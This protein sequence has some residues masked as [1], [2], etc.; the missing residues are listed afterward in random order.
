MRDALLV[1]LALAAVY[2]G[3]LAIALLGGCAS[4]RQVC[5]YEAG[6][7]VLQDTRSTVAGT[8]ETEFATTACAAL[9]YSTQDTGLSDNG[10]DALGVVA[11]GAVRG[12]LP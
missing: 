6:R 3:L 9:S 5:R 1:L 10:K 8:G 4:V 7:L 11:E 2:A 12:A